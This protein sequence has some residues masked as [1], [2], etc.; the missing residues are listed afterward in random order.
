MEYKLQIGQTEVCAQVVGHEECRLTLLVDEDRYE[1]EHEAFSEHSIFMALKKDGQS[2]QVT[3]CVMDGPE[4]KIVFVNGR[5]Y[6][7]HD[8]DQPGTCVRKG[9][10]DALPD[11]VTPPM[12]AVVVAIPVTLGEEVRKGQAVM[13]VSAMKMETTLRAPYDGTVARINAAVTE[14][15]MP[16]QIL[17]EITR[18][19]DVPED[20]EN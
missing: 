4:G 9:G 17:V 16:G 10:A 19:A 12:P 6:L 5:T 14:K 18:V 7:I 8:L 3:A 11:Q 20:R 2:R 13:V 1:I 15:V